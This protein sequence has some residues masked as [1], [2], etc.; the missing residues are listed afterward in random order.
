[1]RAQRRGAVILAATRGSL[2]HAPCLTPRTFNRALQLVALLLTVGH[3]SCA[4]SA[5]A[6][7]MVGTNGIDPGASAMDATGVAG[8]TPNHGLDAAQRQAIERVVRGS[9]DKIWFENNV[10]QFPANARYGFRTTFGA[11]LVYDDHLRLISRQSD[12]TSKGQGQQVV[13]ISF[14]G[15]NTKWTIVPGGASE[16]IGSYQQADGT[17]LRPDIFREL[18]LRDVYDGVDLRLYSANKGI[19]ELDWIVARAQNYEKIRIA[20]AGQDGI[21]FHDDGSATLDLRYQDLALTMP[22]TYQ[23]IDGVKHQVDTRMVAGDAPGEIRYALP[24]NI[25]NDQPLVIDPS[26]AWSTYF[27]LNDAAFDSYLFAIAANTSGVYC[28]GW[29]GETITNGSFGG[30]MEVSA[31]FTQGTAANQA[32]IYRLNTAGTNITAWTSTGVATN[33]ATVSNQKLVEQASDLELFPDGRVLAAFT[34]GRLQIYAATLATRSY[35]GTPVTMDMLNSVAIVSNSSF[36]ASGRVAAAIP[37]AQ[38]LAANIGPDATFAGTLE[39]VIIRYSNATTTPTPDWATYVGGTLE[40]YFTTVAVTPDGTKLVFASSTNVGAAY[41]VLVNA[42]DSTLGAAGTTELLV[43]VLPEQATKPAAFDVFSYLGGSGNEGTIGTNTTVAVVAATNSGFYVGGNTDSGTGTFPGMTVALGGAGSGAQTTYGGAVD[44]FISF[45]PLTG[46]AGSGFQ[47]TYL[48]GAVEDNMG[49]IAFDFVNGRLAV[50][51]TTAGTFP[52]LD[53]SPSGNYF[54]SS[55]GGGFDIFISFFT[56]NL[57]TKEY[58]TFIGGTN[59]D[60][61]GQTGDLLGQGHVYFSPSTGLFYLGTTSHS[62]LSLA[63]TIGTAIGGQPGK[64]LVK[65]NTTD[66]THDTHVIFAFSIPNTPA[67]PTNTATP[68]ATNTPTP[69]PTATNTPTPTP[70]ATNSPTMTPT[71][72]NTPTVTPTAT[73]TPTMTPTATTTATSTATVTP[74]SCLIDTDGDGIADCDDP[75][76][77]QFD[78][79]GF[80]YDEADGRIVPGGLV[81]VSGPGPVVL[82][83]GSSGAYE[84]QITVAGTYTLAVTPPPGYQFSQAC[85]QQDPPPFNPPS[86]LP[87]VLSLGNPENG[88]TGFLTSNACTTFYLSFDLV[89][90]PGDPVIINNNIP[91]RRQAAGPQTAIPLFPPWA[92]LVGVVAVGSGVGLLALRRLDRP[93]WP[94]RTAAQRGLNAQ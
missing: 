70:T 18:T 91:L 78:P 77:S 22:E 11:M 32:Y 14:T 38:I 19:L 90:T 85:V 67:T 34:S 39:G 60:Y 21:V 9:T 16:T 92:L 74:D 59:N 8:W 54:D 5:R 55:A 49:G 12:P 17:A 10:G 30:Y 45:I 44:T 35:D 64:D 88:N 47:S 51:G 41:P 84:F 80:L 42:V 24:G 73:N 36:Y 62:N 75:R 27:E 61:L 40:E 29:V 23:V 31:G 68:T 2:A 66:A 28:F 43:G 94:R 15:A 6:D 58:A 63:S 57:Q 56:P 53:S 3:I 46:S 81:S 93:A 69:T 20:A 82:L 87:N 4:S 33:T 50:F 72:T 52:T 26:L 37:G 83:N 65:S 1:M 79:S 48:G 76:A 25:V 71:A 7:Y 13:D 89:P 86:P